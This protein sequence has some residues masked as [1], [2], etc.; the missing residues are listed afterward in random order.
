MPALNESVYASRGGGAWHV[1][2]NEP[3]PSPRRALVSRTPRLGDGVVCVTGFEYFA[4]AKQEPLILRLGAACKRL[5]GW[6][7][8]YSHLLAATGRAD[9]VVEPVMHPWDGAATTVIMEEA[10]GKYTDWMGR[11]TAHSTNAVL[12]NGLVHDE[13]MAIIG[14]PDAPHRV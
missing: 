1:A 4:R 10:G 13:L 2:G 7:D 11:A 5:R 9:G 12:S 6:S 8:C 3:A 14:R